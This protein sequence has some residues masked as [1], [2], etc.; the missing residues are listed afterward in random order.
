MRGGLRKG[1]YV[2][3]AEGLGEEYHAEDA[4]GDGPVKSFS[5]IK[6]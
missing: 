4:C 6:K 3:G 5:M 1:V 2:H